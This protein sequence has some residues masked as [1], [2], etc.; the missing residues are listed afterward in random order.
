M[1]LGWAEGSSQRGGCCGDSKEGCSEGL[2]KAQVQ[3]LSRG[4]SSSCPS[5]GA[6]PHSLGLATPPK[7]E[8]PNARAPQLHKGSDP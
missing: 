5:P 4:A 8:G 3:T 1:G 7:P 6:Q 2:K